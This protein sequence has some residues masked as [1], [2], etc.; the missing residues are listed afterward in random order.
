MYDPPMAAD[1]L[2]RL[3]DPISADNP[4]VNH[5]PEACAI[6]GLGLFITRGVRTDSLFPALALSQYIVNHLT[7]LVWTALLRWARYLVQTRDMCLIL[8]PPHPTPDFSACAD[9]SL[10]NAPVTSVRMPDVAASS[11]GGFALYFEGSGAFSIECFSPRRLADSSAGAELI[12]AT[13][14]GK[15]VIAFQMLQ[16][17]LG[18][19]R[20]HPTPLQIDDKDMTDGVKMERVSR[21]QRFQAARIDM[22]RTWQQDRVLFLLKTGTEDMRADILSKPVNPSAKF[23]PKQ[24]LLLTGRTDPPGSPCPVPPLTDRGGLLIH[25]KIDSVKADAAP[26]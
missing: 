9:S 6:L 2:S 18:L 24:R 21:E 8:R 20:Y 11:Y 12:M 10:I 23:G 25:K 14:A 19:V 3:R 5:V 22:L 7:V 4:L 16:N 15:S 1:T 17:E 13:W 26:T